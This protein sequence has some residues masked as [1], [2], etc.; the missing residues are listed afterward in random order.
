MQR[1]LFWL[2]PIL[3]EINHN[4][5]TQYNTLNSIIR[6][7]SKTEQLG[8]LTPTLGNRWGKPSLQ[9]WRRGHRCSSPSRT[10]SPRSR[11]PGPSRPP[12]G[13]GWSTYRRA[14]GPAA[15][16]HCWR[17]RRPRCSRRLALWILPLP[18]GWRGWCRW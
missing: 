12:P 6:R 3:P 13:A 11:S 18:R 14:S 5:S 15:P 4:A 16:L 9:R 8:S 7:L 1:D 2:F 10:T 17:W